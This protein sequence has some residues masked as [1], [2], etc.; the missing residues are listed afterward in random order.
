MKKIFSI[1]SLTLFI[2]SIDFTY[3]RTLSKKEYRYLLGAY[4]LGKG[5]KKRL[6][7]LLNK[8]DSII[9]KLSELENKQK[10]FEEDIKTLKLQIRE[11][12]NK[13]DQVI[14]LIQTNC[15][16][17]TGTKFEVNQNI[18]SKKVKENSQEI[19]KPLSKEIIKNF[20]N[21]TQKEDE[22]NS[23]KTKQNINKDKNTKNTKEIKYNISDLINDIENAIYYKGK[24]NIKAYEKLI[25]NMM[26]KYPKYRSKLEKCLKDPDY[27]FQLYIEV[28]NL[29]S[30]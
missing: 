24:G 18:S 28:L 7:K 15:K 6:L 8:T 22:K 30:K 5:N 3:A 14:K 16:F 26:E 29:E 25:K 27:I 21:K 9:L 4:L 2:F 10:N 17:N 11:L 1:L 13:L 20:L 23:S 12:S 19:A